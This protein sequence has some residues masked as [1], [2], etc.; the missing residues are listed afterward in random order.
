M[1]VRLAVSRSLS[2]KLCLTIGCA[3]CSVL[4]L[5]S[6]VS[7]DTS[8]TALE[9]QTNAQAL[10]QTEATAAQL[11]T[12]IDGVAVL[13]RSVAS[14]QEVVSP[15]PDAGLRPFMARLLKQTPEDQ[16][17]DLYLAF[18]NKK[19]PADKDAMPWISRKTWPG[20][21]VLNYDFHDPKQEWYHGA[22]TTDHV[23]VTEPYFDDGG[24]NIAM[25]SVTQ[26]VHDTQGKFIGVAGVDLSLTRIQSIV[27]AN[28]LIADKA[29]MTGLQPEYSFL[30]SRSGMLIAHPNADLLPRKG[31]DGA[32]LE[33]LADGKTA[34]GQ[35]EGFGS[36]RMNGEM[37]R[38]YWATAPITGWKVVM[39]VPEAAILA[40]VNLLKTRAILLGFVAVAFMMALVYAITRKTVRPILALSEAARQLAQGNITHRITVQSAD[41]VGQIA[42]SFAEVIAYQT[43]MA[44]V[45]QAIADGDLTQTVTP[46]SDQDV[47]GVAFAGM[48]VNL[49]RFIQTVTLNAA[50]VAE[51]SG[52]LAKTSREVGAATEEIA[53]TMQEVSQASE[54]SAR[55][56]SE[57]AQGS[58]VQAASIA[59]S[60]DQLKQLTG[61]VQKVAYDAEQATSASENAAQ[62][63][64]TGAVAVTETVAGM[65]RIQ[66]TV[67]DSARV[68]ETLGDSSRQIGGI[69]ETIEE[70]A[71]QTNLL[72]LNAA[73]EAARAGEAGR[74]FAVV[75]DEVRKLAERSAGAT[76][77]IGELIAQVQA[78]TAQA[79]TAMQLGTREVESGA[80]LARQAGSA[81]S[82]I[83]TVSQDVTAQ[84]RT[85]R[86]SAEEMSA[87]AE[88][89]AR[90][91]SDVAAVIEESSAAA[92]EMSASSEEVSASVQTVSSTTLQQTASVEELAA[93]AANLS[94]VARELEEAT[95]QFHLEESE[96]SST[97][98]P[99]LTLRRAA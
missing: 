23:Y 49:R 9:K 6:W 2:L 83:Q 62:V 95:K 1:N 97:P 47:L 88:N 11:D 18:E 71:S 91:I 22:K 72:A 19:A 37:R 57:I 50:E 40:P 84:I 45:A 69:V 31:F 79:V 76:K 90:A 27:A 25:V 85:I 67:A 60:A 12:F 24:G 36:L 26:P 8:R 46:K 63:A 59:E 82:K 13:P 17:Y 33:T 48:V 21:V 29:A 42:L 20:C 39:N 53:A 54:Q 73:I 55:G 75:A 30:A 35:T 70:I 89:V 38:V 52:S 94:A 16:A 43:E 14:R 44:R 41:E 80:A 96:E 66:R 68:I 34:K 86:A 61:A 5:T 10:R 81:L 98:A 4:A 56:A 58:A 93:S 65:D 99:L 77:E 51:A 64:Q 32:T 15:N 92:E 74:G 3:T 78:Q 28:H 7:Y 87:S